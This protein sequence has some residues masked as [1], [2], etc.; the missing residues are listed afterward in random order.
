MFSGTGVPARNS[1]LSKHRSSTHAWFSTPP[2]ARDTLPC[3]PTRLQRPVPADGGLS[4][5][6]HLDHPANSPKAPSPPSRAPGHGRGDGGQSFVRRRE[7]PGALALVTLARLPWHGYPLGVREEPREPTSKILEFLGKKKVVAEGMLQN[8]CVAA[9]PGCSLIARCRQ[10][11]GPLCFLQ[12]PG[13]VLTHA[14]FRKTAPPALCSGGALA[15]P[16]G[17]SFSLVWARLRCQP[18]S[19]GRQAA[20]RYPF[21]EFWCGISSFSSLPS[22]EGVFFSQNHVLQKQ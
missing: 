6:T 9:H 7:G 19:G 20:S 1:T 18:R 16:H 4:S 15:A 5:R 14:R 3:V 21:Q 17:H 2:S 8:G 22:P 12:S 11:L 10:Q 13:E